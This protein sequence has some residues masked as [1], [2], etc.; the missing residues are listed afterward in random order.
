VV[1]GGIGTLAVSILWA[2]M[3]PSLRKIDTLDAP[4]R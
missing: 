2:G 1:I 3:F 4:E